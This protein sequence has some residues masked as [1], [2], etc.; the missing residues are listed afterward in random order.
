MGTMLLGRD[1][2]LEADFKNLEGC[3]EILN[4]TRPDIIADIHDAYFATGIDAVETNTFGANWSN[5]FDYGI[6][7]RIEELARK[8]AKSP[9]NAPKPQKKQTAASAGSSAPWARA[10]NSP[11]W[12]T[13]ATTGSSKPSPCRHKAS[14]TAAQTRSSSKP[15]RTSCRPRPPSTAASKLS[16]PKV[17]AGGSTDTALR[18]RCHLLNAPAGYLSNSPPLAQRRTASC[19]PASNSSKATLHSSST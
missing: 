13:P 9:A 3:N 5:L 7:D 19:S 10:P 16:S 6:G 18:D 14:S 17:P 15:A 11:A 2:Q 4:D 12:A 1:L 8:G